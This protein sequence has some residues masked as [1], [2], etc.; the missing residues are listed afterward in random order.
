MA[1]NALETLAGLIHD[2]NVNTVKV[3]IQCFA[4]VYPLLF[5]K[6]YANYPH[7][8]QYICL[9]IRVRW[10]VQVYTAEHAAPMGFAHTDKD[11]DPGPGVGAAG[12]YWY[13]DICCQVHAARHPGA[14]KGAQRSS[15]ASKPLAL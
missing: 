13:Q 4:T 6:M 7:L 15:G 12:A 8:V 3:A 1:L 5:R 10:L 14:N 9:L 2:A 11:K